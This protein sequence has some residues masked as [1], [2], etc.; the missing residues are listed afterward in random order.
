MRYKATADRNVKQIAQELGVNYLVEGSV[1]R[2]GNKV[3]VTAELIDTGTDSN[4]W[5]E[6]YDGEAADVIGMQTEIAQRISNQLGAK[7]S[8][9]ESTE[10]ARRPTQDIAAFEAYIRARALMETTNDEGDDKFRDDFTRAV[11][12]L[13][14][15]VARDPQF[16]G[17]YWALSE[18]NIQLFR[19]GDSP[20]IEYRARAEAALKE[21]QRIAPE[22]G[23]TL[24]AQARIFYYGYLDFTRALATLEEAAKSLPNSAEVTVTRGL[25][26]RRFGRWQEAFAQFKRATELNPQDPFSCI[27]AGGIAIALRWWDEADQM[28][29]RMAKRFPRYAR[30]A[31]IEH[32]VSLRFRGDV[33]AGNKQLENAKLQMPGNFAELFYPP[34]WKRDFEQCRPLVTE[35]AKYSELQD[36]R[37]DKELQLVFVTKFSFD[38][39]AARDAEKRLEERLAGAIH[40]EQQGDLIIALSNVKMLLGKKNE[41]LRIAEESV[42]QHPISEDAFANV[43]L[44]RR[45]AFM[46]LYAGENDRA[47][48][49]FAKLVQLPG[50]EPYGELMYNPILDGLRQDPRFDEILKQSQQPFP[51]L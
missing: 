27:N 9:R 26:Y 18:A 29:E 44:L 30:E 33:A 23:E 10:L 28:N 8:P 4:I 36:E 14:Q 51:R 45:L 40:R 20:N 48:Q 49:T 25:L 7:L 12:L 22:A 17:A 19:S 5:S 39:Q 21:A 2:E 32:A 41:A 43:G 6:T 37:W 3:H 46:Y 1:Q 24:H 38:E 35:A 42:E 31:T 50:A 34:F 47:L 13:E 15:A 16:A 11:Q